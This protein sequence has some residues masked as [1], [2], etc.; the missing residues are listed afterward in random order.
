MLMDEAVVVGVKD[1]EWCVDAG[2]GGTAVL[3]S[4]SLC[5]GAVELR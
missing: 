3:K 2:T 1:S 5:R 4:R